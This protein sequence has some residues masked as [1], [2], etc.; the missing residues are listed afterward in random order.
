MNAM[1][2]PS[3]PPAVL[4]P[5]RREWRAA[6]R[7]LRILMSDKDATGQVFEIM[8]A[9]NGTSTREGYARLLTTEQGGRLA[10]EHVDVVERLSDRE[11][12][13]SFEPGTL[14]AVYRDFTRAGGISPE[15]LVAVSN[16]VMTETPHPVAWFGRRIRDTHDLWHVLTGYNLDRLG[17][18][19]L[20]AFS[21]AQ[22]RALGWA[23]IALGVVIQSLRRGQFGHIRSIWQGYRSGQRARWL[24]GEDLI[25]LM[26]QPLDAVRERLGITPPTHYLAVPSTLR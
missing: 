5:P 24:P 17:E 23:A 6:L 14:G 20:V 9:L 22:T 10:F 4:Q 3:R 7:A 19:S 12:L 13:D 1:T 25:A 26:H 8:R 2:I 18:A 21:Y 11:W 16:D 15:G